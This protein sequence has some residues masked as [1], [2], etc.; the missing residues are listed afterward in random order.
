M[1]MERWLF[2]HLHNFWFLGQ[3]FV[4]SGWKWRAIQQLPNLITRYIA[5]LNKDS[6]MFDQQKE[7]P[8][9]I[10]SVGQRRRMRTEMI[11]AWSATEEVWQ[12][13]INDWRDFSPTGHSSFPRNNR[14]SYFAGNCNI[15]LHRL[16]VLV[17]SLIKVHHWWLCQLNWLIIFTAYR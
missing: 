15:D 11:F 10:Y 4:Y 1:D 9:K 8:K 13:I 6:R 17:L 14:K 12:K 3:T 2:V 7:G 16:P 5:G